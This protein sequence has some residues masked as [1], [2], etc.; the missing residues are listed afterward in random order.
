MRIPPDR[1]AWLGAEA[2]R[3]LTESPLTQHQRFLL[4]DCV[5]AYLPLDEV[6]QREF[7]AFLSRSSFT[8][9]QAMNQTTFEKG[10]KKGIESGRREALQTTL[11]RLGQ[12]RLGPL[13]SH[14]EAMLRAIDS[15]PTL[16]A[17]I[18]QVVD[19]KSWQDLAPNA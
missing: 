12:K 14:I 11:V 17:L 10:I 4:A 5:E 7:E 18:E 9:V 8:K 16:E 3:R 19:V 13:P 1:I 2:L 6:Q 15:I